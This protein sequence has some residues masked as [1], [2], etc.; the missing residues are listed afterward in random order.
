ED[1][2]VIYKPRVNTPDKNKNKNKNNK[3]KSEQS[4]GTLYLN[5]VCKAGAYRPAPSLRGQYAHIQN[6]T[7]TWRFRLPAAGRSA[8]GDRTGDGRNPGVLRLTS[9]Q[10]LTVRIS[11]GRGR[12]YLF[13]CAIGA[14]SQRNAQ[15]HQVHLSEHSGRR[16]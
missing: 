11:S 3:N 13:F 16:Q 8:Q 1:P 9:Q 4:C 5:I 2:L 15:S 12:Q 7:R 6:S 14:G 10:E